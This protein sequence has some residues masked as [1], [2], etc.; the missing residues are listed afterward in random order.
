MT[1]HMTAARLRSSP[2]GGDARRTFGLVMKTSAHGYYRLP[3]DR[4]GFAGD[5]YTEIGAAAG[6]GGIAWHT[7]SAGQ[8]L[9]SE[10]VDRQRGTATT[11]NSSQPHKTPGPRS[12]KARLSPLVT[13]GPAVERDGVR[14][15]GRPLAWDRHRVPSPDQ[16]VMSLLITYK[17]AWP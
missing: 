8:V 4:H 15:G 7:L 13:P 2:L 12:W 3:G 6:A 11:R 17:V 1:R 16:R 14:S 9:R 5:G 10:G